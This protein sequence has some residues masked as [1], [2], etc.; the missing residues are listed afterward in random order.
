VNVTIEPMIPRLALAEVEGKNKAIHAYDQMI[1]TVRSGFLALFFGAWGLLLKDVVNVTQFSWLHAGVLAAF[2]AFS[3]VLAY[4]AQSIERIY[5]RRK[6]RVIGSLNGLM[7]QLELDPISSQSVAPYL[8]LAGDSTTGDPE[9][10]GFQAEC[11]VGRFIYRLSVLALL[12]ALAFVTAGALAD[13]R[14]GGAT[15]APTVEERS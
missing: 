10:P 1:W 13:G 3:A 15:A 11:S 8:Q 12:L 2:A 7:H 9:T 14:L 5:V 6:Y 4:A